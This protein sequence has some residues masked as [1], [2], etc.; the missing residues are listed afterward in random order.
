MEKRGEKERGVYNMKTKMKFNVSIF[1]LL[2]IYVFAPGLY[3]G[4]G[5]EA[6]AADKQQFLADRHQTKDMTCG[7]CHQESPPQTA[8]PMAACL[9]CHGPYEK[10]ADKTKNVKPNNPHASHNGDVACE[11]CHHGHKTPENYC[12]QCHPT[13]EFKVP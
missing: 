7:S 8:V 4:S 13:F 2:V 1:I 5:G 3:I 10:L 11:S 9:K 6:W 12:A